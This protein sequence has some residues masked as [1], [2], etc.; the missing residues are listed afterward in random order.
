MTTKTIV[1]EVKAS[2]AF[3]ERW[4]YIVK[5]YA[6]WEIVFLVY[7]LINALTIGL[8]GVGSK[9]A[10]RVLYLVIGALLWGYLSVIFHD[11]SESV[12]WERW[13]GT[14]EYTFMA[15]IRRITY[16]IGQS[17]AVMLYGIV[18][19]AI[20]LT[21]V[22]M[23][24]K[25]DLHS[26]DLLAATVV[27]GISSFAFI[28]LGIMAAILPLLSPERGAQATH[29]IQSLVLLVSGV[30]YEVEVLP[31]WLQ[32]CSYFSPATYTLRAMRQALLENASVWT[33]RYDIMV[34]I[35]MGIILI[36]LG[37]Y[38]FSLAE[39]HAKRT[40]KLKRNG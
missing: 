19:T 22:L 31:D 11:L 3:V 1:H 21:I 26:A 36:P 14:I 7:S 39:D 40:G 17:Q 29:I 5:R 10:D 15:P 2:F 18:R 8:I 28:G 38:V 20:V 27:L 25:I 6:S 34:L 13:E 30:Y 33:L 37:L 4:Y 12:A 23:F 32:P 35:V 16:L 24:F 9:D